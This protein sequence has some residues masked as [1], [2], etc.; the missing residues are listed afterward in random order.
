[1]ESKNIIGPEQAGFRKNHCT[2]DLL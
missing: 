2:T 1:V